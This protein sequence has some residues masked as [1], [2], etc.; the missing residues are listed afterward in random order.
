MLKAPVLR[1]FCFVADFGTKMDLHYLNN[2]V[3]TKIF[4]HEQ[5]NEKER[6]KHD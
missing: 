5:R 2:I 3:N 4:H 6:R 1:G